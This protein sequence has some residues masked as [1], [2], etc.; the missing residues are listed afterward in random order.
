MSAGEVPGAHT[1]YEH[2]L[3]HSWEELNDPEEANHID[4]NLP[5]KFFFS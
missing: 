2:E 1:H 4:C 3:E 5:L